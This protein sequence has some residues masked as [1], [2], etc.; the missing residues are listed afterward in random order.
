MKTFL[1]FA[2]GLF[3]L[4]LSDIVAADS[5]DIILTAA[6]DVTIR[7]TLSTPQKVTGKTAAVI[8]IHQGGSNRHEWDALVPKLLDRN[9]IVLAYDVRG[10]GESDPVDSLRKLF[11]DPNLAP[12]DLQAAIQYLQARPNVDANRLAVVGASIGANLAAM[13]SSEYAI[14]TAVAISGKTSAVYNLAGKT[15]LTMRSVFFISSAGDQGGKRAT[16]ATELYDQTRE[17][18][19]LLIVPNSSQHGVGIFDDEPQVTQKILAWL[20]TTL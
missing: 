19:Q 2:A 18:R 3:L 15:S 11:N 20:K 13:A 10:H 4:I 7:A 12:L 16:W 9:Y 8:L 14:K 6:D 5:R 17:P 1:V